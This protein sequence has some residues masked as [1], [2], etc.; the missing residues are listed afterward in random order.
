MRLVGVCP[1]TEDPNGLGKM[2]GCHSK[3]VV[4]PDF[5]TPGRCR[6]MFGS[7]QSDIRPQTR[8]SEDLPVNRQAAFT[9][10]QLEHLETCL[11]EAE[12]KANALLEQLTASEEAKLQLLEKVSLLETRLQAVSQRSAGGESYENVVLEKDKCIEKLQAEVKASQEKLTAHKLKHK[13]AV[14]KLQT[15]L[16]IAK[17]EAAI[18]VLEL[19][20]KIKS[21]CEGR[22]CPRASGSVEV[23][24]GGLPP[25][26]EGDRKIS[27]I[28]ELSTQL[29]LQTEKITQLEEV[30][31]EKEQKIE[32]LVAK[33]SD[34]L[35]QEDA[36]LTDDLQELPVVCDDKSVPVAS[37]EE[38]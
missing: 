20:E 38:L 13:K 1:W 16:A 37:D 26:E 8:T 18:T 21:L 27:L 11:K 2:G 34:Q 29:S 22:P 5:E 10:E 12:E 7:C 25:V 31:A 15:D 28:M 14:K 32:A 33:H 24:Y 35:S 23:P 6:P 19:N 3:K 36:N 30:L 9:L 4:I 17:Q